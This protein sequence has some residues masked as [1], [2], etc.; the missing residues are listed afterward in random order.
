MSLELAVNFATTLNQINVHRKNILSDFYAKLY[1][2]RVPGAP[3]RG[4]LFVWLVLLAGCANGAVDTGLVHVKKV[5]DGDTIILKNNDKVR[6]LGVNTP[7][8]GHGKFRDEP[9][10]NQALQF[11]KRKIQGREVRLKN[12]RAQKDKYGRR[13]AQIYTQ[14]GENIQTG[15]LERG[16]AFVVAI[17]EGEFEY[18]DGYI[19]A[20]SKAREANK[21]VW[22]DDFYAPISAKTAVDMHR[23]R[24]KRVHGNVERVSR[25]RNNQILHLEGDFRILIAHPAWEQYFKGTAQRYLGQSIEVSGW[26]FK[27]H[28]VTGLKIYHP[29]IILKTSIDR[30]QPALTN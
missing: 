12:E 27:S 5:I 18:I 9:L 22:G 19:A 1:N 28:G 2:I 23:R 8:L 14:N 20:E 26:I 13:L 24:Y 25:S 10:A 11:V 16:L 29:A 21:G 17:G 15:L 7:E 30:N 3:V 4:A 6:F